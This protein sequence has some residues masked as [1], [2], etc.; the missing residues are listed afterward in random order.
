MSFSY[1]AELL[2]CAVCHSDLQD[3][4][5]K[6]I[7]N[8]CKEDNSNLSNSPNGSGQN[9]RKCNKKELKQYYKSCQNDLGI[10]EGILSSINLKR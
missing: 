2:K 7:Y 8:E 10:Y 1:I 4:A 5:F 9:C 6:W 3:S